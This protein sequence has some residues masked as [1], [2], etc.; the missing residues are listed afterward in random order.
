METMCFANCGPGVFAAMPAEGPDAAL[1]NLPSPHENVRPR[2]DGETKGGRH[3]AEWQEPHHQLAELQRKRCK[4]HSVF[5]LQTVFLNVV[6]SDG[7]GQR[8]PSK[9]I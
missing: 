2:E 5:L 7:L 3:A 8:Q 1:R 9:R 4:P 6:G